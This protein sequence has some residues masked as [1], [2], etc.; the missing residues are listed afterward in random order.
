MDVRFIYFDLGN[1]LLHFDHRRAIRQM[2][3]LTGGE[4]ETLWKLVFESGLQDRFERGEVTRE[5]FY[6]IFC[7]QAGN[8]PGLDPLERAASEIFDANYALFPVVAAL[9]TGGHRLGVLSNTCSSHWNYCTGRYQLLEQA[10]AV[11]ALS[12]RIGAMKPDERIFRA[13]AELAGVEPQ[14]IFFTDD[15]PGHVEAARN[16]G[17]DAVPYQSVPQLVAELR[18][19]GVRFTY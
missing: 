12:F 7:R 18:R 5:D 9:R 16:A 19:R 10:F 14:E 13:A 17:F 8:T 3:E 2:A 6:E 4:V 11:H 15:T 1:V